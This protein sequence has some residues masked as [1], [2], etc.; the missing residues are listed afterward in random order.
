MRGWYFGMVTFLQVVSTSEGILA[1]PEV[2]VPLC[3]PVT[4]F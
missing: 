1:F 3:F 2:D 4:C